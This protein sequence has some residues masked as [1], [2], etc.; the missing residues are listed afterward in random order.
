M[1]ALAQGKVAEQV[2]YDLARGLTN[3]LMHSPSVEMRKAS[4]EGR[5]D[6]LQWSKQLLGIQPNESIN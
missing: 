4:S 6:M 5:S 3:K 2:L 1:N